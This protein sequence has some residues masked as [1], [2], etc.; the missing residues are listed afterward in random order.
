M[1]QIENLSFH[2][3]FYPDKINPSKLSKKSAILS[4]LQN[5]EYSKSIEKVRFELGHF[6]CVLS[7]VYIGKGYTIMQ[8]TATVIEIYFRSKMSVATVNT[9]LPW[10]PWAAR[11]K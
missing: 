6:E 2:R 7:S 4:L 9:Y 8:A 3:T 10:P 5:R 11:N 1:D